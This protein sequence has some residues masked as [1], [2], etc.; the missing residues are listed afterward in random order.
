MSIEE[1][2]E[3]IMAGLGTPFSPL[4]LCDVTDLRGAVTA[5]IRRRMEAKVCL[6]AWMESYLVF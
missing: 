1:A 6:G 5:A 2:G 3:E 4:C